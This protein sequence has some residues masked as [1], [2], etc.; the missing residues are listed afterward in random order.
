MTNL[1]KTHWMKI[2]YVW[3]KITLSGIAF[4]NYKAL[5]KVT[6]QLTICK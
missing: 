2:V 4:K 5:Q 3:D 6:N 1:I